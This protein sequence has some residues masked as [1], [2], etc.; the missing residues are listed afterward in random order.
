MK[1]ERFESQT[2]Y[3]ILEVPVTAAPQEIHAAYQ[4]AKE[5][6]ST[7]SPALYTMFTVEEARE[8][9]NL[10]EE[11]FDTLSNQGRRQ[12]YDQKLK[13]RSTVAPRTAPRSSAPQ[14]GPVS[15]DRDL[16]DFPLPEASE[17]S[18]VEIP[19]KVIQTKSPSA[20]VPSG[21]GKTKFG[22]Y[23]INSAFEKEV[24]ETS[25]FN[26]DLL[27]RIRIYKKISVDQMCDETRINKPY[28]L[29]LEADDYKS[30][31]APV[32]VRGFIIQLARLYGINEKKAV[33]TYLQ[34]LKSAIQ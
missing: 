31:P 28:F 27:K 21:F 10:I 4:R 1:R 18:K 15:A 7:N 13:T 6:Y 24:Q 22:I 14:H 19:A 30:L 20:T 3:D 9:L 32:F 11:A 23:E 5:T 12:I 16:P 26:G 25:A 34:A 8:L 17:A 29:A 33:E 2:Y